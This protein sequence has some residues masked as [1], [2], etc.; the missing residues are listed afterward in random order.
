MTPLAPIMVVI[1]TRGI[2]RR[3]IVIKRHGW[4]AIIFGIV[5]LSIIVLLLIIMRIVVIISSII[6]RYGFHI[7]VVIFGRGVISRNSSGRNFFN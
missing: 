7:R 1:M 3:V 2:I 6:F 4:T 5:G